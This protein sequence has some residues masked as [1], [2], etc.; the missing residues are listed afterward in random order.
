MLS[1]C[2]KFQKD[3]GC[4]DSIFTTNFGESFEWK[5]SDNGAGGI[6]KLGPSF[7]QFDIA[8]DKQCKGTADQRQTGTAIMKFD[9]FTAKT[10]VISMEGVAEANHET[11]EL[12]VDGKSK[13]KV[14]ASD[15]L[16]CEAN[17]CRMCKVTREEQE[18]TIGPGSHNVTIEVDTKD[19]YFHNNSYFRID[20]S[21][22]QLDICESCECPSS[23]NFIF[24]Y[25]YHLKLILYSKSLIKLK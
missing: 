14:Q 4:C 22:K 8:N 19:A 6:W 10:I 18:F 23:G 9:S 12:F 7:I 3:L 2:N 13:V 11:F 17:T 1:E 15:S 21:V 5:L 20:F 24:L 25:F 16:S